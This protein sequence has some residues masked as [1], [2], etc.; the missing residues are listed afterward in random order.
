VTVDSDA[1]PGDIP[2]QL[3]KEQLQAALRGAEA[4]LQA[5]RAALAGAEAELKK[6][7]V[8]AEGPDVEFARRTFDRAEKLYAQ[9]LIS[10][11]QLDDAHSAIDVAE[12]RKRAAQSQLVVTQAKVTQGQA[13][14]DRK[15]TRLKSSHP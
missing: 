10:Q 11:S 1:K 13:Q 4:N 15:R 6:N 7:V 12:N 9:K 2:A 3:D 14:V 8:E 5:A